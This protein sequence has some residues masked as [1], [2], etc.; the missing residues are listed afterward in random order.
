MSSL[1]YVPPYQRVVSNAGI[2]ILL[3]VQFFTFLPFVPYMPNWFLL[4]FA[5]V[6]FWRWRV[7]RGQLRKPPL[8]LVVAAIVA[9]VFAIYVSGFRS[10]SL[11]TAVAFC[12][13]GY[14]L[15]SLEVLRRRDGVFQ[16]Y[17]GFF[18]TG[19][20]LLYR[21]DPVGA[22][23]MVT[24][25]LMNLIALQA[26]TSD[27][28]FQWRYALRQ[29]LWMV[30]GAIPIMIMGYLFFPRIP[31]L[32]N[33]P[34]EQRGSVTGM[35]DELNPGSVASL[36]QSTAPAFRVTFEG[37]IPPR[38]QWY[39]R[40][41]TLGDFDGETWRSHY[42]AN[43][44]FGWPRSTALPEAS[45]PDYEYQIIMENSGQRWLY[46]LDWPISVQG[47]RIRT[48][49]DGRGAS[50]TPILS[51]YRYYAASAA[52]VEW[53]N[54]APILQDNLKL[55]DSGN[56]ALR[57]WAL[58]QYERASSDAE[59]VNQLLGHIRQESFFY[60]LR[61]PTYTG[62]NS[63]ENFWLGDRRG[64]CE[65][66]ASAMTYIL[67]A[68]G[69]PA[70]IVGGYLGGT[71][72]E[73]GG[74]IQVR[75]ME[76]HAWVEAWIDNRWQRIDPTAAVAPSRIEMN[77]D[78]LFSQTQPS[79]LPLLTRFQG[80]PLV[81]QLSLWWDLANYQWQV[82]VLDYDNERALAWFSSGFGKVTSL[83]MVAFV[84]SIMGAVALIMAFSLGMITLPKRRKEPYQTLSK[85]QQWY[86]PRAPKETVEAYIARLAQQHPQ[87]SELYDIGQYIG[88]VLYNPAM[89]LDRQR[90]KQLLKKLRKQRL[91]LSQQSS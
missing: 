41:N 3:L 71:F 23:I 91:E 8:W 59:F 1:T 64:F 69:I 53:Q 80:I 21:F 2:R 29:S 65:H 7:M 32:W 72:V 83:K 52:N 87:H 74:Y 11:D 79:D 14:L 50:E 44:L 77:L 34:N 54:Q 30:I 15:K 55:P 13:L 66:Y 37:D 56:V 58:T 9:G 78:D 48:L 86:G 63:L 81:N 46:F 82:L 60:T 88:A 49:P 62:R 73:A 33:I 76:A 40:G 35:S 57:Q 19:V 42:S 22:V 24:L 47:E 38:S 70:R 43:R 31:P 16:I 39:W 85:L 90:L 4:V 68:V 61:P 89:T 67:R 51:L 27:V 18:L 25:L 10:Y 12:L 26:V 45:N 17:L 36:A 5:L 28:L 6:V 84:L 20:Y 75:Q